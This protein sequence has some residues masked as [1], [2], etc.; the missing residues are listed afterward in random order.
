[1]IQYTK[2]GVGLHVE[3]GFVTKTKFTLSG[4]HFGLGEWL[5]LQPLEIK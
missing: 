2:S 3:C 5:N 1:V 4:G